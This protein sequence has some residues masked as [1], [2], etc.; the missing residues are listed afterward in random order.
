MRAESGAARRRDLGLASCLRQ[1]GWLLG[2]FGHLTTLA[3]VAASAALPACL[4]QSFPSS[5]SSQVNYSFR[6]LSEAPIGPRPIAVA[7]A[8]MGSGR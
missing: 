1:P 4:A 6:R 3:A 7:A 8:R 2:F 5:R